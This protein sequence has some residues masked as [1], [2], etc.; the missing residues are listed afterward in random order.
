MLSSHISRTLI[1]ICLPVIIATPSMAQ[2]EIPASSVRVDAARLETVENLRDVTGELRASRRTLVASEESGR[3]TSIPQNEGARVASGQVLATLDDTVATIESRRAQADLEAA[4]AQVDERQAELQQSR[5]DLA[6]LED[7]ARQSSA[8]QNEVDDARTQVARDEARLAQ[9]NALLASSQATLDRAIKRV[10]DMQIHAPYDASIVTLQTEVGQWVNQGDAVAE[11]VSLDIVESW[12]DVP[13]RFVDRLRVDGASVTIRVPALDAEFTATNL[14]I[15]P[16]ADPLARIFPVRA[17]ISNP[18]QRLRP[19]MSVVGLVPTGQQIEVLTLHKDAVLRDEAGQFVYYD[20]G[21]TAQ[22]A[23]IEQIF[24]VNNRIAIH[25]G[26]L[27]H[28]TNIIIEGN[29]R[30]YPGAPISILN[31]QQS[32]KHTP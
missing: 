1:A 21:G 15:I 6:R 26:Q 4:Q 12:L 19:G 11:I 8:S 27:Q 31:A 10:Q 22:V 30:L 13:E 32:A 5:R 24:P 9:A 18:E 16:V 3:V 20:A 7:L 17:E 28:G 25:P 14:S 29:E 2:Y 23:R